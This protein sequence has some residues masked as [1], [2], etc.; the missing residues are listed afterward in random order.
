[1][2]GLKCLERR[3]VNNITG[4]TAHF[5]PSVKAFISKLVLV[6]KSAAKEKANNFRLLFFT[7]NHKFPAACRSI[8]FGSHAHRRLDYISAMFSEFVQKV[9]QGLFKNSV[10]N[11]M[12]HFV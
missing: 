6:S 4:T 5:T 7:L 10:S 8:T 1:M 9:L 2:F 12:I 3:F 11:E